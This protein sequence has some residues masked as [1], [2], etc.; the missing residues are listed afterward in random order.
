MASPRMAS[1]Y[2]ADAQVKSFERPMFPECFKC[3]LRT[4]R[5]ET[6]TRLLERRDADLIESDQEHEWCNSDLLQSRFEAYL[7]LTVSIHN[8]QAEIT[9]VPLS[10]ELYTAGEA[11][12]GSSKATTGVFGP[13]FAF[14]ASIT[15]P[16]DE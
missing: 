6:A 15:C 14:S 8:H 5:G 4:G 12:E 13:Y 1:Q 7:I 11:G 16:I 9:S 3:I 2:S 10:S